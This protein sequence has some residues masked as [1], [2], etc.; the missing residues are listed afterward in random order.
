AVGQRGAAD[1]ELVV[2][3][4]LACDAVLG[5]D[6]PLAGD[7]RGT[8]AVAAGAGVLHRRH[9]RIGLVG[10]LSTDDRRVLRGRRQAGQRDDDCGGGQR[11]EQATDYGTSP[12]ACL[13]QPAATSAAVGIDASCRFSMWD[14][15]EGRYIS[16]YFL[17]TSG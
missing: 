2:A 8:A 5:R 4:L 13:P 7:Q 10:V 6:Q 3:G 11:A 1:A 17:A 15:D 14:T 16:K 12:H 9:E